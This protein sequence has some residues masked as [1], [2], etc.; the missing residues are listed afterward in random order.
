MDQ[1][2]ENKPSV[3]YKEQNE[4]MN[5]ANVRAQESFKY[6]WRELYWESRRIIPAHDFAMIKL[7]FTQQ[8]TEDETPKV[9]HMWVNNLNFDGEH[10]TGELVNEPHQLTNI[11]KGD[12]VS[13]KVNEISDWMISIEEKTYGGFTIHTMRAT[14]GEEERERHDQAWGLNFGDFNDVLLVHQQKENPGNLIEH[15]MCKIMGSNV[16]A[17]INKNP[18]E[19]TIQDENGLSLLHKEAIAGNAEIVKILL[20]LGADKELKSKSN[21]TALTYAKEMNWQPIIE[22]LK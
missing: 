7:A 14:M 3:I 10:I 4:K 22:I 15:P 9:E 20:D 8:F 17:Y 18:D 12:I 19:I 11:E 16:R 5:A 13:R 21:K 1:N 2:E 6:F